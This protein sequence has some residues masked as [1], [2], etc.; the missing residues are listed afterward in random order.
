MSEAGDTLIGLRGVSKAYRTPAGPLFAL[1][2]V[3][4]EVRRGSSW[5]LSAS[6]AQARARSST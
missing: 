3:D 6:R 4:L 2:G 1:Q 5:P